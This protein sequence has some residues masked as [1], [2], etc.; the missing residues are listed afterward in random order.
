MIFPKVGSIST[1]DVVTIDIDNSISDAIKK[2][3]LHKHRNIVVIDGADFRIL[4]VNDILNIKAKNIDFK[5]SLKDVELSLAPIVHK[6]KTVLHT[7]EFLNCFV[8]YIC[9]V[10][11]NGSLCGLISH[12]D[13]ISSV[14]PDTL[15][16][17]YCLLDFLKLGK[18]AKW[19]SKD[20]KT[21][22]V[23]CEMARKV[24][25]SVIIVEDFKPIGIFTTKDVISVIEKNNDLDL[26][27]ENYMSAPV[28]TIN[29]NASVKKA[30]E[31][32]KEKRFKRVIVVDD[33]GKM[34]GVISQK[35]LI[36]TTYSKWA[37]LTKEYQKEL[38]DINTALVNK[39]EKYKE[40]ASRDQL[41]KLYN[42]YRFSELY[43]ASHQIMIE[44]GDAM[45]LIMVDIDHFKNINDTYGHN[46]GDI[47]L[48]EV[49]RALTE[50]LRNVDMVCRWGGEEFVVLLPSVS[51][52]NAVLIAQKLRSHIK[53][54]SI[55]NISG[56]SA[57]F[58]V[59]RV[60]EADNLTSAISRADRALYEAKSSGRDC[61]KA[62]F[63]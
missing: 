46:V 10:D 16:D 17:N 32:L 22:D 29:K 30:L 18:R 42:R 28:E 14:D 36:A 9:V 39:N 8:E 54:L 55:A 23:L 11:D 44:R 12:T 19:I 61:V 25:E 2:M 26:P 48:V 40:I 4:D 27:I 34:F 5:S 49:S 52:D 1:S 63:S 50:K 56:I 13:I 60:H 20:E 15:M 53:E 47:V 45:S 37:L 59:C 38:G 24:F 6:D 41:T 21:S 7:L 62:D 3:F 35:E 58:G 31:F 51:L 57:S 33:D 43:G